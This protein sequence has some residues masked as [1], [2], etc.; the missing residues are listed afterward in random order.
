M[1][2]VKVESG[3][4]KPSEKSKLM[5]RWTEH[6]PK[7][8]EKNATFV[9]PAKDSLCCKDGDRINNQR[10]SLQKEKS[11]VFKVKKEKSKSQLD[12]ISSLRR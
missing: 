1:L 5:E 11:Q 10:G 2:S 12:F 4:L 6:Q 7:G 9:L 3:G 8:K